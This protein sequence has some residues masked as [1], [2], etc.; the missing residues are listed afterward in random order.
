MQLDPGAL[1]GSNSITGCDNIAA[2]FG[3]GK[4]K[5]VQLLQPMEGMSELWRVSR[6]RVISI[7]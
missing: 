7:Q 6:E 1:I 4:W 2:F 3:K 5:A